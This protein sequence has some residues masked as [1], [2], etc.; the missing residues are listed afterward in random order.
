MAGEPPPEPAPVGPTPEQRAAIEAL[1]AGQPIACA[2]CKSPKC[3]PVFLLL[4]H[5]RYQL[6][7]RFRFKHGSEPVRQP[8]APVVAMMCTPCFRR[9]ER[10]RRSARIATVGFAV[11]LAIACGYFVGALAQAPTNVVLALLFGGAAIAALSGVFV[12]TSRKAVRNAL[13]LPALGGDLFIHVVSRD[14][15]A[16]T[17]FLDEQKLAFLDPAEVDRLVARAGG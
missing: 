13:P 17:Q 5:D 4:S 2:Q 6:D 1:L 10:L 12:F 3:A 14:R 9:A 8:F 11:G 15:A 16:I 7:H